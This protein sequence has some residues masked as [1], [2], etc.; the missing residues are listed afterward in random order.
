MHETVGNEK[1][2]SSSEIVEN[3]HWHVPNVPLNCSAEYVPD[4]LP[5]VLYPQL[6]QP[7]Q[8]TSL[9]MPE[10]ITNPCPMAFET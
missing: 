3:K 10:V 9:A 2:Q 4:Y 5:L 1:Q 6:V 7:L 8:S